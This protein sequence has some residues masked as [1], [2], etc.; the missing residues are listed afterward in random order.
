MKTLPFFSLLLFCTTAYALDPN[1]AISQYVH[2]SW[3]VEDGLPQ[4]SAMC[5]LQTRDGYLWIGTEEGLARFDGVRFKV[6][7][8]SN[9]KGIEENWINGLAEDRN[10]T[11]WIGTDGGG[12]IRH[13]EEKFERFFAK[14]MDRVWPI[15][16]D[17]KGTLWIGTLGDGLFKI[18]NEKIVNKY[19]IADGLSSNT[20]W[21]ILEDKKGNL[22]IGTKGGLNLWKDGKFVRH[23][24]I[25]RV[26]ALSEDDAGNLWAGNS[27]GGLW[28]FRD[29]KSEV[30]STKDGLI[31]NIIGSIL[32]DR[33]G[34]VWVGTNGGG[35]SRWKNGSF[36][37]FQITSSDQNFALYED[38]EG[39]LWIGLV[40]G[41]LH[42][43]ADGAFVTFGTKEG[44]P[45]DQVWSVH[46]SSRGGVW[47]ATSNG[48]TH[49]QKEG[50]WITYTKSNGLSSNLITAVYEDSQGY[51]WAGT[52][53]SGLN[54]CKD[55]KCVTFTRQPAA[56]LIPEDRIWA[57]Q[58]D[59]NG[60]IWV[61]TNGA[62]AYLLK[63]GKFIDYTDS[64]GLAD[65]DVHAIVQEADDS[66][67]F[68]TEGGGLNHF[69]S[70]KFQAYTTRNGLSN[71]GI[72]ALYIDSEGILW[73]GTREGLNRFDHRKFVQIRKKDGLF[74]D[75]IHGIR[76][77]NS[78]NVWFS[79][80]RG[81]FRVGKKELNDFAAG[82]ITSVQ[83]ISYGKPDGMRT[84]ECIGG[85]QPG[86][87]KSQDGKLWFP[88]IQGVAVV[89][90][91]RLKMNSHPPPV[92]V[93]QVFVDGVEQK[94]TRNQKIEFPPGKKKFE[95]QYTAL[96][97]LIPDRVKFRYKLEG[98]DHDWVDAG[99][100]RVA[101]YTGL[102][103]A[104]YRFRITAANNDGVWS[105]KDDSFDFYL[106]PYFYQTLWFYV[107]CAIG[108][109]AIVYTV[110][111]FRVKRMKAEF[112]AI[113]SER[114]RIAREIHDTF[115]QGLTGIVLQLDAA[116]E[117]EQIDK[118]K[119][120][121]L[122]AQDLARNS[123]SEARRT[124]WGLRPQDL[125]SSQLPDAISKMARRITAD[126]LLNLQMK[127]NGSPRALPPQVEEQLLRIAQEAVTNVVKHASAKTIS[128]ELKY[129]PKKVEL[130]VR[131][132]GSGF[133]LDSASKD[134]HFGLSGMKERADQIKA[135]LHVQSQPEKGTE[136]QVSLSVPS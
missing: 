22:W 77:D 91:S 93:E 17:R 34:N 72:L 1:K 26:V 7:D 90:P 119:K 85:N 94:N 133:D 68:G 104:N 130:F 131:D 76:E 47:I 30:F 33:A 55:G 111:R 80:N 63:N 117:V 53:D 20:V 24:S 100:R 64:Q 107:L 25:E 40:P 65:N 35:L 129:D 102:P 73:I 41:G 18:Q 50:G 92:Y 37:S 15:Y 52:D 121:L 29:D 61:G 4:N 5:I 44:L 19:T 136:I 9:T 135:T 105:E 75:L 13:K 62:G 124:I 11:L 126:S 115:A 123:L 10:G 32:K 23:G 3:Q 101:Y 84:S 43:L 39:S 42:R 59:R 71:D 83:S 99:T 16:E 89:D 67:W 106:K 14:E 12:I 49:K 70:G 54:R 58:E 69:K 127:T 122:K 132:D 45:H 66:L 109:L 97:L 95:F 114:T 56:S 86:I 79:C 128:V 113:I 88:T 8:K 110:Y 48:V 78:G 74:D 125:E 81:V 112:N 87:W 98:F 118:S 46:E 108:F 2:N 28:R 82:K 31:N 57:L 38:R 27:K 36:E 134:D 120:H 60:G 96:S 21:S 6:F 103:S 51:L 116:Q